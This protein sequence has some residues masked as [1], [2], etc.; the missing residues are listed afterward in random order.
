VD[1]NG[2]CL[3]GVRQN[4]ISGGGEMFSRGPDAEFTKLVSLYKEL[5]PQFQEYILKQIGLLLEIQDK[6]KIP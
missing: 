6:N 4:T 2:G 1:V 5:N 3:N